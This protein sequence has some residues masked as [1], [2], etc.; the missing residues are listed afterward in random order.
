MNEPKCRLYAGWIALSIGYWG[1]L[2]L[3]TRVRD[4]IACEEITVVVFVSIQML[5]L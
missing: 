3:T 4:L 2:D 1:A 5:L